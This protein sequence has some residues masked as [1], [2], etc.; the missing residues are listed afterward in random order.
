MNNTELSEIKPTHRLWMRHCIGKNCREYS[1]K[2]AYLSDTKAGKAKI[3]LFGERGY[4]T[5]SDKRS[6]RYIDKD[7]LI[8]L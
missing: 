6:I 3:V 5:Y 4:K 1:L 8:K 2:C 7:R